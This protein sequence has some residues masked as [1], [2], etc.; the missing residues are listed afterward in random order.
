MKKWIRLTST[1][2]I[3]LCSVTAFA[4]APKTLEQVKPVMNQ[5]YINMEYSQI[6]KLM[7]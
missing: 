4:D 1:L 2:P 5:E 3:L 7:K 6:L